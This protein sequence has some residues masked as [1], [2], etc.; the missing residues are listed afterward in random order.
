VWSLNNWD[1][2]KRG[3]LGFLFGDGK[4]FGVLEFE[5]RFREGELA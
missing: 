5:T 4:E 3:N 1:D 2:E